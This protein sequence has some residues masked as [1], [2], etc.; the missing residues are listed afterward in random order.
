MKQ[1]LKISKSSNYLFTNW[2][3]FSI[4]TRLEMKIQFENNVKG[5]KKLNRELFNFETKLP[6]VKIKKSDYHDVKNL[7]KTY[8]I[9]IPKLSKRCSDLDK[10][11]SLNK[12]HKAL[13]LDTEKFKSFDESFTEDCKKILEQKYDFNKNEHFNYID[14]KMTYEDFQYDDIIS[15]ILTDELLNENLNAKSFSTIGHIAHFNLKNELTDYKYI[16]GKFWLQNL[17]SLFL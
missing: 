9:D 16:I 12:T 10:D 2:S 1:L 6:I 4:Y 5:M 15:F 13:L 7:L 17:F 8:L 14:V 11:D 3:A